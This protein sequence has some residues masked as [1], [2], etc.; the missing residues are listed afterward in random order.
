MAFDGLFS[1]CGGQ[2][3]NKNPLEELNIALLSNFLVGKIFGYFSVFF[4][5]ISL[6]SSGP[7][8]IKGFG[9]SDWSLKFLLK[10]PKYFATDPNLEYFRS[11]VA[12]QFPTLL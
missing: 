11:L 4:G 2:N 7:F 6:K 1:Y 10:K 8:T 12:V 3:S 9:A 5:E